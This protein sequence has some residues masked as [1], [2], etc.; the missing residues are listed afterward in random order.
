[1][2][3]QGGQPSSMQRK[4]GDHTLSGM[5]EGNTADVRLAYLH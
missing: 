4:V 5:A 3:A 1:M 2:L